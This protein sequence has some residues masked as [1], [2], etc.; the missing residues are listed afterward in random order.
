MEPE[1]QRFPPLMAPESQEV[2]NFRHCPLR[3]VPVFALV[4]DEGEARAKAKAKGGQE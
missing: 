2:T 3:G 4:E 1:S